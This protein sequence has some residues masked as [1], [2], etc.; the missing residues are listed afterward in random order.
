M[1]PEDEPE[2]P[3][4]ITIPTKADQEPASPGTPAE[5]LIRDRDLSPTYIGYI[6]N[7]DV[8]ASLQERITV[9]WPG[10]SVVVVV[11]WDGN[12]R[13]GRF[14]LYVPGPGPGTRELA[15]A[16][17]S[18]EPVSAEPLSRLMTPLGLYRRDLAERFDIR[19]LSFDVQLVF[20]GRTGG[21][22]CAV[23][24][25]AND[26]EG[27]GIGACFRCGSTPGAEDEASVCRE[28]ESWPA[29][30]T[31]EEVDLLRLA[32]LLSGGP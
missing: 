23:Y 18:A 16:I 9:L 5:V 26:P 14:T 27:S 17:R 15:S 2:L 4:L 31:G 1:T 22:V 10:M 25:E 11:A 6:H 32:E 29:V 12:E 28:G 3:L 7:A 20:L 21:S 24:G 19:F 30:L 8:L 13:G